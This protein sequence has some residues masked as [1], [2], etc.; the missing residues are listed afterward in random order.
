M[1]SLRVRGFR[2]LAAIELAPGPR[3]NVLHGENGAGKSSVLE[4]LDYLFSLVS[5]RGAKADDMVALGEATALLEASVAGDVVRRTLRA[6]LHRGKPRELSLDGKRPRSSASW[7]ASTPAVLF[8]PQDLGLG[9]GGPEGRR[10]FLDRM[11]ARLDPTYSA[12]LGSYTKALKSRNR[13]LKMERVDRRSIVAYHEIL[14][15]AGEVIAQARARLVEELA[16]ATERGFD[17][18][19]GVGLAI[20]V[21]YKPRVAASRAAILA[22]LEGSIDKDLARGFTAEGPHADDLVLEAKDRALVKHHASQ[23]QHRALVLAL[24]IAE[25]EVLARRSGRVPVLLLDDVSS[26]LD[27]A[28]NRRLFEVI[29]G[30]GGQVFLTTTHP[31]FILLEHDRVDFRIDGGQ[32]QRA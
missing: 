21:R 17:Q 15:G 11:L 5:F 25:L 16:P 9:T 10:A 12:A 32:V 30:L 4:A 24:K 18:V 1:E 28:R 6:R 3:F 29:A 20:V 26:E 8:S 27:R 19:H 7:V 13:L 22:A 31:E 2:N 14:A 23:G